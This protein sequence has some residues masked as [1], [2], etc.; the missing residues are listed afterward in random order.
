MTF[1]ICYDK[2]CLQYSGVWKG[3]EYNKVKTVNGKS[4]RV[5]T[6]IRLKQPKVVSEYEPEVEEDN[7]KFD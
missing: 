1:L 2:M 5:I 3:N 7:E 6:N 4:I